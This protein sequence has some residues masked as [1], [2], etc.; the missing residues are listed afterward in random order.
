MHGHMNVKEGCLMFIGRYCTRCTSKLTR[1]CKL[2]QFSFAFTRL[3][4]LLSTKESGKEVMT[5]AEPWSLTVMYAAAHDGTVS[6]VAYVAVCLLSRRGQ[7]RTLAGCI[8]RSIYVDCCRCDFTRYCLW[9][10][11]GPLPPSCEDRNYEVTLCARLHG[12][13]GAPPSL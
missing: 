9:W 3:F 2:T 4:W 7:T 13:K 11:R 12:A 8:L 6:C 5:C 1:K 10:R